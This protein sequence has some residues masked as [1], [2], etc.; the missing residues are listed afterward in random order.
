MVMACAAA[1]TPVESNDCVVL[2]T[3]WSAHERGF[4]CKCVC[5]C[6]VP[7][8]G[9]IFPGVSMALFFLYSQGD[10]V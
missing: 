4:V 2:V 5:V 1:A 9:L 10:E 6:V 8:V 7:L 3:C